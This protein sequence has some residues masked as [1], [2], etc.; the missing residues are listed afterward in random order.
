M[1]H[2]NI[3]TTMDIYAE[4]TGTKLQETMEMLSIKLDVFQ[5]VANLENDRLKSSENGCIV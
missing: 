4:A 3:E 5:E 1:G 2:K